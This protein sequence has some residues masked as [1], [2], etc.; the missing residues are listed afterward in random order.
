MTLDE[1]LKFYELNLDNLTQANVTKKYRSLI[2]KYHPDMWRKK[3]K[4]EQDNAAKQFKAANDAKT[5]LLDAI[6]NPPNTSQETFVDNDNNNDVVNHKPKQ[7][8]TSNNQSYQSFSNN[9]STFKNNNQHR[10]QTSGGFSNT[11][12]NSYSVNTTTQHQSFTNTRNQQ[13]S[14]TINNNSNRTVNNNT[15]NQFDHAR[16]VSNQF[17]K[18]IDTNAEKIF[19]QMAKGAGNVY[20]KTASANIPEKIFKPI[21]IGDSIGLTPSILSTIYWILCVLLTFASPIVLKP[22]DLSSVVPGAVSHVFGPP[23]GLIISGIVL[24]ISKLFWDLVGSVIIRRFKSTG[25]QIVISGVE[26]CL[27]SV[28]WGL[29]VVLTSGLFPTSIM[30]II[31][32]GLLIGFGLIGFGIYW[33][34]SR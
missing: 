33:K 2:V 25:I 3:S 6:K 5:I 16:N 21:W 1:A 26:F 9:T 30:M 10:P 22:V 11:N 7:Q 8:S 31:L 14:G 4:E 34:L 18:N 29:I 12:Q 28:I 19:T 23:I 15:S 17:H 20:N 27:I 24:L 32:V 13:Q